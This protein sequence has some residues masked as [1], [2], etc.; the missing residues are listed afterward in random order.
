MSW[1]LA[2]HTVSYAGAWRGQASLPVGDILERISKLGFDGIMLMAKRPQVSPLDYDTDARKQL[3][4]K[5]EELG[6]EIACLAGYV[7]LTAGIERQ[8][9]PM[10]EIHVVYIR[11]LAALARDLGASVIRLF[12]GFEREGVVF[13]KQ[14]D[15]CVQALKLAARQ[16]AEFGVTLAVQN[17]H[18]LA[19]HHDSLRWMLEEV[20]EP[21]CKAAFDAWAP[22]LQGLDGVGMKEAVNAMAPFMVHT[23]AADYVRLPRYSY[24]QNHVN[25]K[26]QLDDIRAVPMGTG[27]VDYPAF[28]SALEEAGYQGWVAYE[29]CALLRGGGKLENLDKC[30]RTFLEYMK[31]EKWRDKT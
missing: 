14:W 13:D 11:E 17:H 31:Q 20:D 23:T 26:H 4:G 16:A 18:D 2:L 28:F 29:M 15:M 6:L 7:D 27:L 9:A 21:N 10:M 22:A 5:I 25:F 30:A 1:K 8:M 24:Q 3:K 19:V 12:T